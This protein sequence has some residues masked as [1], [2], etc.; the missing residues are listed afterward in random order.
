MCKFQNN[1]LLAFST[2]V[3]SSVPIQIA[4]SP[5]LQFIFV[6]RVSIS[7][8]RWWLFYF[9]VSEL[10]ILQGTGG[11]QSEVTDR[12]DCFLHFF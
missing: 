1:R 9:P 8:S 2:A 6:L 12:E 11:T 5:K 4:L 10:E 3:L 7:S